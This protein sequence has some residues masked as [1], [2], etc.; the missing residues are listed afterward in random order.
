ME[1]RMATGAVDHESAGSEL[2]PGPACREGAA[3]TLFS[4]IV[5]PGL[6]VVGL[7]ALRLALLACAKNTKAVRPRAAS[8]PSAATPGPALPHWAR[9]LA[10]ATRRPARAGPAAWGEGS[11][12]LRTGGGGDASTP[13]RA[14]RG[15]C[16]V[17]APLPSRRGLGRLLPP[18]TTTQG[19]DGEQL[20]APGGQSPTPQQPDR[21]APGISLQNEHGPNGT[22]PSLPGPSVRRLTAS[23]LP[24]T[25]GGQS[26][27]CAQGADNYEA[28]GRG[29]TATTSTRRNLAP[30]LLG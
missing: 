8:G 16:R 5:L 20:R 11:G 29:L 23:P 3:L 15:A 30:C 1:E 22:G 18:R 10:L 2:R 21:R 4:V 28:R 19:K 7:A 26:R 25:G 14:R 17:R 24:Q 9:S 27:D 13:R 12:G 6:A